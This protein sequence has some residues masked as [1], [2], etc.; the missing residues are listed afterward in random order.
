MNINEGEFET[1]ENLNNFYI[2]ITQESDV[3]MD[4]GYSFESVTNVCSLNYDEA[5]RL[6]DEILL[7]ILS[8]P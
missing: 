3:S 7:F 4:G 8:K 5:Q 1:E 2:S 6:A